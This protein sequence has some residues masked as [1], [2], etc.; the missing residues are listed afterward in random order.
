M[1]T[2]G[3]LRIEVFVEAS[4]QENAYLLWTTSEPTAWIVDPGFPPIPNRIRTALEK[5]GLTP[6]AVLATHGHPDHIAGIGLL[7]S[8]YPELV[9]TAPRAERALFT[10]PQANLSAQMGFPIVA[11]EPD[12]LVDAGDLLTLGP[13]QWRVLD[14]AGHSPGGVAYYCAAAGVVLTGDALFAGSIGRTDFPGS[15]S[16]RLLDNIRDNLLTLPSDT[17]IYSGHGPATTIGVEADSNPFLKDGW[18][19]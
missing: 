17:V 11:P 7:K 16:K 9:V 18:F 4:F 8:A 1:N 2:H 10:D 13:L 19:D 15:S 6:S 5:H 3:L 12:Q 14:V